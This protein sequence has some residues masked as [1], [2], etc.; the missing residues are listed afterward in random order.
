MFK[1]YSNHIVLIVIAIF[2]FLSIWLSQ[3]RKLSQET[4]LTSGFKMQNAVAINRNISKE[5]HYVGSPNHEVVREYIISELETLGLQVETQ[6]EPVLNEQNVYSSVTNVIARVP[7]NSSAPSTDAILV[8]SHYDSVPYQS[9]G[10]ADAGS[11]V[12]VILEGIRTI[13]QSSSE[14]HNDII[15]LITDAE[16]IGLLGAKAF[17]DKHRWMSDVKIVM[18]FEARGT[19]GPAFMF[20]ETNQG[21]AKLLDL[22][23]QS[24]VQYPNSNS[25]AY[26]IYKL[27]PNDTDLTVFRRDH[28]IQGYNFA[29]IDNHF[30]YHTPR[31]NSD[32]LS[33]NSLA[34]QAS[35]LVPILQELSITDLTHIRTDGDMV[36]FQLPFLKTISYPFSWAVSLSLVSLLLFLS[37]VLV[38]VKKGL[39]NPK[40]ILSATLPFLKSIIMVLFI[41]FA[42]LKFL[43]WLHPHYS[44]IM[45]EFT[46]NGY[47]YIL[48]FCLVAFSTNYFLYSYAR[49]KF[50][51]IE[52]MI[53]PILIWQIIILLF[54]IYLT[55][56]HFFILLGLTGTLILAVRVFFNRLSNYL[57]LLLVIPSIVIFVP[58]IVQLPVALGLST[59]PFVGVLLVMILS[60]YLPVL[61]DKNTIEVNRFVFVFIP[62]A[63]YI[64]AETQASFNKDRP[65]PDSLYYFQDEKTQKSYYYTHD[66]KTDKWTNQFFTENVLTEEEFKEFITHQW[67][68]A[69]HVAYTENRH[70]PVANVE[71]LNDTTLDGKRNIKFLIQ[72]GKEVNRMNLITNNEVVIYQL[73][74]NGEKSNISNEKKY[75]QQSRLLRIYANQESFFE[76]NM[77]ASSDSDIDLSLY[78]LTPG[79]IE[80][81]NLPQRPEEFMPKPFVASDSI[82][83]KQNLPIKK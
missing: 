50:N 36:Y 44:E 63:I 67:L 8:M 4:Q 49:E 78:E 37:V 20:M 71:I 72:S 23:N 3:P 33:L 75:Q 7:A 51:S 55:G 34:H 45:Q 22:F 79:L 21:N 31:D 74:I 18:N 77:V 14:R 58:L 68:W 41:C 42:L 60:V 81:F 61:F 59:L 46:Y 11:G 62:L 82:V 35:Y 57:V 73:S 80:K 6:T 70:I 52:L 83:T 38:T 30:D 39:A 26:S 64:F 10:A 16:E 19:A 69:K 32:N 1:K 65:L 13:L 27:L 5:P 15:I 2:S 53:A 29:F 28:D 40:R 56:A 9:F 24:Q 17:A 54:S 76:V 66:Y 48:F 12:S 43:Y 25:L 47:W